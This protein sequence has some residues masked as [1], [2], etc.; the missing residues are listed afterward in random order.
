MQTLLGLRPE[1]QQAIIT[2]Y[3]GLEEFYFEVFYNAYQDY[4]AHISK[5]DVDIQRLQYEI[6]EIQDFLES[7]GVVEPDAITRSISADYTEIVA[8]RFV[9]NKLGQTG[10]SEDEIRN[11]IKDHLGMNDQ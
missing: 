5:N 11:F 1:I 3:N 9:E 7:I 6:Y 4:H 2:K 8:K 10:L